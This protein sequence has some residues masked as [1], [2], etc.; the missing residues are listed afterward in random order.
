MDRKRDKERIAHLYNTVAT[1]MHDSARHWTY[2]E[3]GQHPDIKP[4]LTYGGQLRNLVS[5]FVRDGYVVSCK[6]PSALHGNRRVTH[7]RWHEDAP[8]Y[9]HMYQN[10]PTLTPAVESTK[11]DSLAEIE[12]CVEG[13]SI[14]VSRSVET[15][16][17]RIVIDL[18]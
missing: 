1:L 14:K 6:K 11:P 4:L 3:L 7:F 5:Y 18:L 13:A 2:D 8:A 9:Q 15:N 16:R 12:F 17:V 10:K